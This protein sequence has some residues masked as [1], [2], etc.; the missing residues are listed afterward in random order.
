MRRLKQTG[1]QCSR[2]RTDCI[3]ALHPVPDKKNKV[4]FS[5]LVKTPKLMSCVDHI[6]VGNVYSYR[7]MKIAARSVLFK[8]VES[9]LT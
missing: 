6:T 2:N 1:K 8:R 7:N 9:S 3:H 4:L 5:A